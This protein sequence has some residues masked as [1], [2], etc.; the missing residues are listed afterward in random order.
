MYCLK[1]G[2]VRSLLFEF[3]QTE[4]P[5]LEFLDLNFFYSEINS[6]FN[7]KE[8][9]SKPSKLAVNKNFNTFNAF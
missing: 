5:N 3:E 8:V 9:N 6:Y 4:M 1:V 7:L 2:G